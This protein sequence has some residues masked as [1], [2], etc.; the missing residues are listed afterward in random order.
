MPSHACVP[1]LKLLPCMQTELKPETAKAL[2]NAV[3]SLTDDMIK[4]M[5]V[6]PLRQ[7]DPTIVQEPLVYRLHEVRPLA[8]LHAQIQSRSSSRLCWCTSKKHVAP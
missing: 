6:S 8:R 1:G 3:P 5:M 2:Q 7:Y 4:E